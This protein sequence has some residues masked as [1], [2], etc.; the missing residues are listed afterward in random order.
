[1]LTATKSNVELLQRALSHVQFPGE[2]YHDTLVRIAPRSVVSPEELLMVGVQ[3]SAVAMIAQKAGIGTS[4]GAIDLSQFAASRL[5]A[6]LPRIGPEISSSKSQETTLTMELESVDTGCLFGSDQC[7]STL[8]PAPVRRVPSQFVPSDGE[9]ARGQEA[10]Y[11]VTAAAC[12]R[13]RWADDPTSNLLGEGSGCDGVYKLTS[14]ITGVSYAVKKICRPAPQSRE[15]STLHRELQILHGLR[16]PSVSHL[17]AH[18]QESGYHLLVL[19]L[20]EEGDLFGLVAD[21]SIADE[22]TVREYF[23]RIVDALQYLHEHNIY[24]RDLKLENVLVRDSTT[25][26]VEIT[27][28][29]H[30]RLCHLS[31]GLESRGYGTH[32]YMAPEMFCDADT[33][34]YDPAA[35]DVWSLGV[36]LYIMVAVHYPFGYD[37]GPGC[38][39]TDQVRRRIC[40]PAPKPNSDFQFTPSE[41]FASKD[42]REL[43]CGMLTVDPVQRMTI[44]QIQANSWVRAALACRKTEVLYPDRPPLEIEAMQS[45]AKNILSVDN[46]EHFFSADEIEE[47]DYSFK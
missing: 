13:S 43:L 45:E 21:G 33:G 3:N 4:G 11:F 2:S 39:T 18:V 16:H 42:L 1:M 44:A 36:M 24:H 7:D 30:S 25:H 15:E 28:F 9:V 34:K 23:V 32:A 26:A 6:R 10:W 38:Q 40:N 27:D 14:P 41:K 19:T 29:G 8:S 35:V 22:T 5:P 37:A 12:R 46:D 31:S 20:C 17:H 47:D